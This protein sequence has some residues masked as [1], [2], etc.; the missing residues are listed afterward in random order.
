MNATY[1]YF[2]MV[3]L[4]V[5]SLQAA[6]F[7]WTNG[8]E[9]GKWSNGTNWNQS[10]SVPGS[11]D[12]V[13]APTAFGEVDIDTNVEIQNFTYATGG[14]SWS[15]VNIGA[16]HTMSVNQLYK[17]G[18]LSLYFTSNSATEKLALEVGELVARDGNLN[19]GGVNS[20]QANALGSLS[21]SGTTHVYGNLNV[22]AD[23]ASLGLIHFREAGGTL[24]IAS[25]RTG[26]NATRSVSSRG[27]TGDGGS[28][29]V[30]SAN[31]Q[32]SSA[33]LEGQL[34]VN[35]DTDYSYSGKL[36][37][38]GESGT[39]GD[40]TLS[41][42]KAGVGTQSLN[43][44]NTYSGTTT[45]NGGTLLVNGAHSNAGSYQVNGGTL[46][47]SGTISTTDADVTVANGAGLTPGDNGVGVLSL[48][49]GTGTLD[50]SA[51]LESQ[52]VLAYE[53]DSIG[54]SDRIDLTGILNIG[55]GV[56]DLSS[57]SF[58]LLSG[59]EEGSY[60]LISS[61]EII[62]GTLG[63]NLS[64]TQDGWELDLYLSGDNQK[65]MMDVSAIPEV[66]STGL[67]MGV[68]VLLF[69]GSKRKR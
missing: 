9:G 61:S 46:G 53:L 17:A 1:T 28:L 29:Y 47:G 26:G 57:F 6:D 49:L 44:S 18:G 16:D 10:G 56:L 8:S 27:L 45:V 68:G 58:D 5:L 31:L 63:T 43:G 42:I 7:S 14:S 21:V 11:S 48:N 51:A 13:V 67:L 39:V 22:N 41:L 64:G 54:A 3:M 65:V 23:N 19:L 30:T 34:T 25:Y 12:N 40:V 59:V 50:L 66:S 2:S 33:S 55:S 62:A 69:L 37:D 15:L 35:T 4:S 60:T 20:W 36:V 38:R 32:S 52:D 24:A